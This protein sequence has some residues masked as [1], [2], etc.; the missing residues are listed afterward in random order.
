[1]S[2]LPARRACVEPRHWRTS[3]PAS[4]SRAAR[5]HLRDAGLRRPYNVEL[6]SQRPE[7]RVHVPVATGVVAEVVEGV[8]RG[9]L[10]RR[11]LSKAFV[12]YGDLR[13][14]FVLFSV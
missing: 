5:R 9:D 2:P 13:G 14:Q 10:E 12:G 11:V 3:E 7:L 1:M 4:S 8:G 6:V